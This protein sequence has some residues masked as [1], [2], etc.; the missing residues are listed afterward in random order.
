MRAIVDFASSLHKI[1]HCTTSVGQ[2]VMTKMNH[3]TP[4]SN[5]Y[6]TKRFSG[7]TVIGKS[8]PPGSL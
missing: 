2:A 4:A 6:E 3:Y 8:D 7:V 1:M 5:M